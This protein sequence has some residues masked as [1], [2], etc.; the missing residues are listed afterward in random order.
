LTFGTGIER[1]D[2]T[3]EVDE[4]FEVMSSSVLYRLI[5]DGTEKLN[6]HE[7]KCTLIEHI[8]FYAPKFFLA[9]FILNM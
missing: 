3:Q 9:N 4:G 1:D 6:S 8:R 5:I 2:P 7:G